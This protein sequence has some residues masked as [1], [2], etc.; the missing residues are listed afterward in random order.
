MTAY[1]LAASVAFLA[2]L[3]FYGLIFTGLGLAGIFSRR[4]KPGIGNSIRTDR[5]EVA[6]LIPSYNEGEGLVDAVVSVVNQDYLGYVE[7]VLLLG[8]AEDDSIPHL[9]RHFHCDNDVLRRAQEAGKDGTVI[10]RQGQRRVRLVLTGLQAKKDKFNVILPSVV[11]S[12]TAL[13]DADHRPTE[14]WISSSI[15]MFQD[16]DGGKLAAVQTRRLPLNASHLA[17][18]WDSAQNHLGNELVNKVLARGGVFFTGTAAVFRTEILKRFP[19]SDSITEDTY[20]SYDLWCAGY[21]IAYNDVAASYEEVAPSFLAYILRRRRWSAGHTQSFLGHLGKIFRGKMS[22]RNRLVML[23]HGQFYLIPLA[24]WLLLTVY[25]FYFFRQFTDSLQLAITVAGAFFAILLSYAFRQRGRSWGRALGDWFVAIIWLMPQLA[26][27]AVYIYKVI[28]SER[29]Y[30]ILVFPYAHDWVYWH[31][32]LIVAPLLAFLGAWWHFKDARS[33]LSLWVIPTYIL[34]LFLDIYAALLGFA[35]YLSGRSRWSKIQRQNSYSAHLPASLSG[36]LVT[37]KS[38]K[39][40]SRIAYI[41]G[42]LGIPV[43]FLFNDLMAVNNCGQVEPF[44]WPPLLFK[45]DFS[46]DMTVEYRREETTP[47]NLRVRADIRLIEQGVSSPQELT[48]VS[49]LDG[50]P[51]E[52]KKILP[53]ITPVLDR[54]YALGWEKHNLDIKIKG[55]GIGRL[56]SCERHTAFSTVLKELRGSDLYVNGEKFLVKGI[57]PSFG[58][59]QTG[60][61]MAQGLRQIKEVGGNAVRFYHG[62]NSRLLEQAR[63]AGLLVIDQPDRSTWGEMELGSSFHTNLYLKRYENLVKEHEGEPYILWDGLGN[64]WELGSNQRPGQAVTLVNDTLK[65]AI[66]RADNPLSSYSTYFTFIKYPVDISGINMLDTGAT[67]WDKALKM[68]RQ[69]GRPFYASEFGGFVAFWEKTDPEIRMYR[70]QQEWPLLI[71]SGALGANFYQS[72]DNWAQSVVT[73]YNDPWQPEQ[74]D[75]LRGFWDE[76]NQAKPE[77]RVLSSLLSD[78]QVEPVGP[79]EDVKEPLRLKVKN[80]RPYHLVGVNIEAGQKAE[81]ADFSSQVETGLG[82]L[83]PGEEKEVGIALPEGI[84]SGRTVSLR[85]SYSTHAGLPGVSRLDLVLPVAAQAPL[86]LNDDFTETGRTDDSVAGR[87]LSSAKL[88]LLLPE[89]WT[90]VTVNG[91]EYQA[92]GPLQEVAIENPYHPVKDPEISRDGGSWS[93]L[94]KPQ[95]AGSGIYYVR[96]LWP[97]IPANN[98]TLVLSG[99]GDA[100]VQITLRGRTSAWP[101]HNYRENAITAAELD[102]PKVGEQV[103]IRIDRRQAAYIDQQAIIND[104]K[105]VDLAIQGNLMIDLEPPRVFAPANVTIQRSQAP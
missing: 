51:L 95:L 61:D 11:A 20:L 29:Y 96:F 52:E 93:P 12:F 84:V 102:Y 26:T 44:L 99:V 78:V 39:G 55:K 65:T 28:G 94:D 2:Y 81:I 40:P 15:V 56:S 38:V 59:S 50:R 48:L 79:I 88:K 70:L 68:V 57:I 35:D 34:T 25:G 82:N 14:N 100:Q 98:Q 58:N 66:S 45:P 72:H 80:I 91:R 23:V 33:W 22:F 73:G 103:V 90:V 31:L 17:Q 4:K 8:G 92:A 36:S 5:G 27:L 42:A 41:L 74:P 104:L 47:G 85:F 54:E 101:T 75:D 7:I 97:E 9:I 87:L 3:S 60:L 49:Y 64:E 24:V 43:L 16:K 18:I 63:E 83:A 69:T 32:A 89:S 86:V 13:L 62:A 10:W 53:G 105:G 30:Y 76:K 6:V 67:Y 71:A 37:G 77:L 21:R 46:L 1:L 19:L